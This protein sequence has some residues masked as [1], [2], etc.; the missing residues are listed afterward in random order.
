[1]I[2]DLEHAAGGREK[3]GRW[4]LWLFKD[5]SRTAMPKGALTWATRSHLP[6]L[7]DAIVEAVRLGR[8]EN[9][10]TEV[11]DFPVLLNFTGR[12]IIDILRARPKRRCRLPGTGD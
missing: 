3:I 4:Q 12:S 10:D 5:F 2:H 11:R 8:I 9:G 1:M 6:T 7:D